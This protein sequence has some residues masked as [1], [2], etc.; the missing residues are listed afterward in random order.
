MNSPSTHQ[1]ANLEELVAWREDQRYLGKKVVL[2]NGCFDLLHRGHVEYLEA[3]ATLGDS[4][5]VAINSDESVKILKGEN[6]PVNL[7]MDRAFVVGS[8]KSV[9]ATF[10]FRGPRLADEILLLQP[11]I[12]TKAGD[13]TVETLDPSERKALETVGTEVVIQSF[14]DGY[15]TT[16]IVQK[17]N[18]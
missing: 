14:V 1:L 13:Y 6:R 7:E 9:T 10:I 17:M 11:D 3:S 18:T 16:K 12:Y 8:L 15:S 5:I 4:L 2:T